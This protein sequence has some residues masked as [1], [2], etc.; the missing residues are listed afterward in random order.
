MK[1]VK[2]G[3]CKVR[4]RVSEKVKEKKSVKVRGE[5]EKSEVSEGQER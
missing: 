1:T 5:K 4:K 3:L 2:G